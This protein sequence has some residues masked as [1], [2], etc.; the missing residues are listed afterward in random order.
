L[1]L[2]EAGESPRFFLAVERDA[3][4]GVPLKVVRSSAGCVGADVSHGESGLTGSQCFDLAA[5]WF[6]WLILGV[7]GC[8][9]DASVWWPGWDGC[10]VGAERRR[11][12][13]AVLGLV[14]VADA[15]GSGSSAWL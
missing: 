14:S 4:Q 3:L 8:R 7:L 15:S 13:N 12:G 1:P 2:A 10:V 6:R 9:A 5:C 11:G